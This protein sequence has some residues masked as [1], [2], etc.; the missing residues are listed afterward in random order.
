VQLY[1][2]LS[3]HVDA[4]SISDI[5]ALVVQTE[6]C[7]EDLHARKLLAA[8]YVIQEHY[9]NALQQLEKIIELNQKYNDNYAQKAILQVFALL[10][11]DHPLI[12]QYRPILRRYT[13]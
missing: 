2:L 1:A 9:A 12:A 8:H 5:N 11:Q 7:P 13:H 4:K 3:F 6:S 10:G